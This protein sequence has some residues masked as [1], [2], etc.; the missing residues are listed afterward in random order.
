MKNLLV[1][2]FLLVSIIGNINATHYYV[3]PAGNNNNNG[4][5]AAKP[6]KT[7]DKI[8]SM[9][10]LPGDIISLKGGAFF[11]GHLVID[12]NGTS[13]NPIT[14][15]A[16]GGDG[17]PTI[18]CL[19]KSKAVTIRA[20]HFIVKDLKIIGVYVASTNGTPNDV[21]TN[22]G[23]VI[24][25][26]DKNIN[27]VTIDNVE[28]S[29]FQW[30]GIKVNAALGYNINGVDIL[31]SRA[32][33]NGYVGIKTTG[34][35][36]GSFTHNISNVLVDNCIAHHN[37]GWNASAAGSGI[38]LKNVKNSM[39][40]HCEAHHNGGNNGVVGQGGGGGIWAS[41]CYR[42]FMEYNE[43]HHN[44]TR[45]ADGIGFNF[46]G[47]SKDC[48]MQYN[49]SH[50]N[51]GAGLMTF[52]YGNLITQNI[53]IR[54]NISENDGL[55]GKQG[56]IH[57]QMNS[58]VTHNM[59]DI[60]IYQNT[61]YNDHPNIKMIEIHDI[62]NSNH[63]IFNAH[64]YN[65]LFIQPNG[66]EVYDLVNGGTIS[67]DGN[68]R[69]PVDGNAR[70]TNP[71]NGLNGYK[72]KANSP[73]INAG[74]SIDALDPPDL[75]FV[76]YI[77]TEDIYGDGVPQHGGHDIGADE[78]A[79]PLNDP[80]LPIEVTAPTGGEVLSSG[81][82]YSIQWEQNI[83]GSVRIILFRGGQ[84][85]QTLTTSTEGDGQ[86][87]WNISNQLSPGNNYQIRVRSNFNT[88]EGDFSEFF[89]IANQGP[90]LCNLIPNGKFNN[91][92]LSGW[93]W[94]TEQDASGTFTAPWNKAQ[95]KID[96]PGTAFWQLRLEH[97]SIYLKGGKTYQLRYDAKAWGSRNISLRI[98]R[99]DNYNT[100]YDQ[101]IP[102]QNDWKN[103]VATF[104]MPE[105]GNIGILFR[106]GSNKKTVIL[107]NI[108][109]SEISCASQNN[110]ATAMSSDDFEDRSGEDTTEKLTI[111]I[112]PNPVAENYPIYLSFLRPVFM[113]N[114][115]ISVIITD[116]NGRRVLERKYD[117]EAD[118]ITL[119]HHLVSGIY[120]VSVTN[121]K[122]RATE[123]LVIR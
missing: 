72:L 61:V 45:N 62:T 65:N 55:D 122:Q 103:S 47:G 7:L 118:Q 4:T 82:T 120:I 5:S 69:D 6:F 98:V 8:N 113:T 41:E 16:Y 101:V 2:L 119:D 3:S 73:L 9:S 40:Q 49:Y 58:N 111:S 35:T 12:D 108:T 13:A 42:I 28:V 21:P 77:G 57:A 19:T 99:K 46:D 29:R 25:A 50:D 76:D 96:N 33:N 18:K 93:N 52:Q 27:N 102:L 30:F 75:T 15:N 87:N 97:E 123:K 88:D 90:S 67:A 105:D 36:Q 115:P 34:V 83:Q 24:D 11:S 17:R 51:D 106:V 80:S 121:E 114:T 78:Y 31:N 86:Y 14:L 38:H 71:G 68:F 117:L 104:T 59:S 107:D 43:S 10:F 112:F 70:L 64:A 89:S 85:Q 100:L 92:N 54:Y 84:Y 66:G 109:L 20:S 23:L 39:I 63:D 1:I 95:L 110:Q 60:F 74:I 79:G 22:A 44:E 56:A 32:H 116:I 94:I 53:T 81:A 48:V 26:I 37:T 91:K